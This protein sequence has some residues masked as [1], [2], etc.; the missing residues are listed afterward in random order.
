M[1]SYYLTRSLCIT[2]FSSPN[3][4]HFPLVLN[5]NNQLYSGITTIFVSLWVSLLLLAECFQQLFPSL[6]KNVSRYSKKG[7]GPVLRYIGEI[8]AHACSA[9]YVQQS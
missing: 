8:L 6:V 2:V 3:F 9:E 1:P 4:F 5:G 7:V